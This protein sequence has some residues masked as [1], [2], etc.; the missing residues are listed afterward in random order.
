MLAY[1]LA[2]ATGTYRDCTRHSLDPSQ[3]YHREVHNVIDI[4]NVLHMREQQW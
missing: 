4:V 3:N 2:A 1:V